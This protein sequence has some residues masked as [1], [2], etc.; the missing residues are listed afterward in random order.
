MIRTRRDNYFAVQKKI[1][2]ADDG[3]RVFFKNVKRYKSSDKPA[4]FDVKTLCPGDSDQA[5][6]EKLAEY[7]NAISHEFSALEPRDIPITRPKILPLIEPWDLSRRI[8]KFKKP[9]SMVKGDIFPD[10]MTHYCDQLALPLADVYNKITVSY[11]WPSVWKHE[12]VTVIPK[13]SHPA[14]FSDLRNISCTMLASKVYESYVLGWASEEV[15]LKSNQYG[16]VRGCS[17]AHMLIGIWDDV[18]NLSLIHI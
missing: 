10:L 18:Y 12:S 6:A 9:K 14:S 8:K 3:S 16:G 7:F 4:V 11:V 5:V 17:T 15:T 1:I 2:L 13:I